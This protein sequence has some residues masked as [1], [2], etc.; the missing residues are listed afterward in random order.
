MAT[1]FGMSDKLGPLLYGENQEEVFLGHSVAKSQNVSDETQKIVDAEIKTFVNEGY[2]TAKKILAE[3]EDQL[4]V[5]AKGLLEYETL[6]GDEIKDLL[7]GKSPV[8][9]TDDDQPVGRSSAVPSTGGKRGG[10]PSGDREP[11]P[12]M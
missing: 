6:S 9:E 7:D 11:Q 5:I 10:E 2:E 12:Q 3:H 1:Q 8:R 4:H